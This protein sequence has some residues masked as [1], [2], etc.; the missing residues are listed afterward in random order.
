MHIY[1]VICYKGNAN[2]RRVEILEKKIT[3][4]N[5][6]AHNQVKMHIRSQIFHNLSF[7]VCLLWF[8][9]IMRKTRVYPEIF[10]YTR[11][12]NAKNKCSLF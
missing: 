11:L 6:S 9:I 7:V 10:S 2:H 5:F 8:H 12:L 3:I 4:E 1:K